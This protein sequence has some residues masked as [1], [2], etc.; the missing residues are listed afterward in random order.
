MDW[1]L[2]NT[3]TDFRCTSLDWGGAG[4]AP[5]PEIEKWRS[6]G[7]KAS[8]R[9]DLVVYDY[10]ACRSQHLRGAWADLVSKHAP[11][12]SFLQSPDFIDHLAAIRADDN[13]FIAALWD[14]EGGLEGL[15]P[16]RRMVSTLD[17]SVGGRR[18]ASAKFKALRI[19]GGNILYPMGDQAHI[20]LLDRLMERFHDIDLFQFSSMPTASRA[21]QSISRC[22]GVAERFLT[23]VPHGPRHCLV[24]DVPAS[25]DDYLAKLGRKK[26]YNLKRQLKQLSQAGDGQLALRRVE[27]P[28]DVDDLV[29]ALKAWVQVCGGHEM[30]RSALVDLA[31]RGLL[32]CYVLAFRS[33]LCAFAFGHRYLDTLHVHKIWHNS[34][35][36]AHSPGAALHHLMLQDIVHHRLA[37]RIDYGYG[38]PRHGTGALCDIE[39]RADLLLFKKTLRNRLGIFL[40]SRFHRAVESL[41]S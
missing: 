24:T 11:R 28:S 38:M 8:R 34:E 4:G 23:Y 36:E 25:M 21:W 5:S 40:H 20:A 2:K 13:V 39:E 18:L 9:R 6:G 10:D 1:A 35:L 12:I 32:L 30:D 16:I 22:T 14:G 37:C 15:I 41:K 19:L 7:E 33:Q 27:S 31:R 26:R 3:R 17:F 29:D